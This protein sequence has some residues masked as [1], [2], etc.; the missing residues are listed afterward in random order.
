[1]VRVDVDKRGCLLQVSSKCCELIAIIKSSICVYCVIS[2]FFVVLVLT[3]DLTTAICDEMLTK[4][5]SSLIFELVQL[6]A[7][8][9]TTM[10]LNIVSC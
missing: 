5:L 4:V 1:M 3:G 10:P 7:T 6:S 8:I 9:M 2:L